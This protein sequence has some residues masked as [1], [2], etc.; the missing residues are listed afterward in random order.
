MKATTTIPAPGQGIQLAERAQAWLPAR[1]EFPSRL[2][3]C[4]VSNL[5]FAGSQLCS[6]LLA[7]ATFLCLDGIAEYGWAACCLLLAVRYGAPLVKEFMKEGG[8]A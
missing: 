3:G 2:L 6:A 7:L 8:E 4:T 5:A 1:C